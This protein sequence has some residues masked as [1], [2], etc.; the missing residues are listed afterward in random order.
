MDGLKSGGPVGRAGGVGG[1]DV[2][3][4]DVVHEG[5]GGENNVGG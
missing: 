1:K 2:F 5:R 4:D 3:G